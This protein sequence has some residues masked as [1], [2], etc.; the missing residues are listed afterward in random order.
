VQAPLPPPLVVT[1]KVTGV[2]AVM[3]PEVPVIVTVEVPAVAV[4]LAVKVTTLEP[5]VG[6]APKLA[7]T[8]LGRPEA[9]R[10]TEPLKP[11]LAATVTVSVALLPCVTDTVAEERE[12]VKLG[13]VVV[14]VLDVAR[15]S[16]Q[17]IIL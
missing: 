15:P 17:G 11:P 6:L 5:V 12:S 9:A 16:C 4:L 14:L 10:L 13:L 2:L 1:V 7:V 3:L 8:P